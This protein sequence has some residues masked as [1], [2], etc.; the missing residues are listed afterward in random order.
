MGEEV[1]YYKLIE[2]IYQEHS[3]IR[4][5]ID[6]SFHEVF[7]KKGI[8]ISNHQARAAV[9][10]QIFE[11]CVEVLLEDKFNS[12]FKRS[13]NLEEAG[14]SRGGGAD[15]VE[16]NE[17]KPDII[18]EVKGTAYKLEKENGEYIYPSR[19]GL[20]RTDTVKKAVAQAYQA[21][22]AYPNCNFYIIT[23]HKPKG[24][25]PQKILNIAKGDVIDK[26]VDVTNIQKLRN[27]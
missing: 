11:T 19:P 18:I 9:T 12:E 1:G 10:G 6:N 2:D 23:T 5:F 4:E 26:V 17:G 3:D 14:M 15:F 16:Y 24:N 27:K 21:K 20:K 13:V 22:S 7:K 8:N 25:N